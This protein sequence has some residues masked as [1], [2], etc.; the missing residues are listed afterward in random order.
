M[1]K[2][3]QSILGILGLIFVITACFFVFKIFSINAQE[4]IKI[5]PTSF[6]SDWQKPEAVLVQDLGEN[7]TFE[8]FNTENSSFP[9]IFQNLSLPETEQST[10][11]NI[12]ED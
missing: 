8:E 10:F 12:I 11:L 2:I 9:I 6:S 1:A 5:F 4:K 7:A 3:K